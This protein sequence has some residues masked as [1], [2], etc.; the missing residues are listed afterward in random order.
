MSGNEPDQVEIQSVVTSILG[1]PLLEQV[2]SSAANNT[3]NEGYQP[4]S[5][6]W[7]YCR[8]LQISFLR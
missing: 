1:F 3:E 7:I 4:I 2:T 5:I 6:A 8:L